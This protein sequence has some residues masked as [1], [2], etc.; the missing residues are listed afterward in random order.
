[1]IALAIQ[2]SLCRIR[3]RGFWFILQPAGLELYR[4]QICRPCLLRTFQEVALI[5]PSLTAL[6][7]LTFFLALVMSQG[8]CAPG[9]W[10]D[11]PQTGFDAFLDTI[12][13][14]CPQRIGG[15]VI[16]TLENNDASF[17][18]ITSRLY[19]GKI[20]AAGYRQYVTAFRDA[21][22]ETNQGIDCIISHLPQTPPP[23]PGLLPRTGSAPAAPPPPASAP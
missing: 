4:R 11:Q 8:G 16:S 10:N 18:D 12:E 13:N 6:P 2:S 17:L 22:A 7:R 9:A 1:V 20:D 15:V 21:S 14:Q 19:Y 5:S 23:A 3:L